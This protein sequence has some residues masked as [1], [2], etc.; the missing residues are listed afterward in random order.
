MGDFI[1]HGVDWEY[2][3]VGETASNSVLIVDTHR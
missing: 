1:G 3:Q 2:R